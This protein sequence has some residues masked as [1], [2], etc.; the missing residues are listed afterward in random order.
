VGQAFRNN[1]GFEIVFREMKKPFQ[2]G[3]VGFQ[4]EK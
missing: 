2:N 4:N 3:R 1:S